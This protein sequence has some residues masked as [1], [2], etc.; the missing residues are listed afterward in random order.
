M[1]KII[2]NNYK[3]L[4]V[5]ILSG[6]LGSRISEESLSK[7]KPLVEIADK[8]ILIHIIEYYQ[9]FGFT[10]FI[11]CA[12]Y[13]FNQINQYFL[14][15]IKN[16]SDLKIDFKKKKIQLIKNSIKNCDISII[17]TGYYSNTGERIR[18]IKK[19][20]KP[21]SNFFFT[22]G[23]GL[24]DVNI[25]ELYKLHL[26]NKKIATISVS[27]FKDRFGIVKIKNN[28]VSDFYEKPII[29]D[30]YIN[31]GF[32]ILNFEVFKYFNNKNSVLEKDVLSSLTKI[33][34]LSAYIH[35]GNFFA[36]DS[37]RD[38]I[39]LEEIYKKN[40]FWVRKSD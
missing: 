3:K 15:F 34:Q 29:K 9:S 25:N 11:I 21:N 38:K 39:T 30:R 20:I 36:M 40:P 32:G 17:D 14:K 24:S 13:K 22:Y 35:K 19:F 2:K 37:L 5:V 33:K 18:R 23:D 16:H 4:P 26:K 10:N 12:G 8:A 1:K 31:I 6:G 7:P 27:L 28:I